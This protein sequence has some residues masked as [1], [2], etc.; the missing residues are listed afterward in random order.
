MPNLV[1]MIILAKLPLTLVGTGETVMNFST[2][3][4]PVLSE[5]SFSFQNWNVCT[6]CAERINS[7][8]PDYTELAAYIPRKKNQK[9]HKNPNKK[10]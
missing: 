2:T 7:P 6:G 10:S 8:T 9:T 4:L 5:I 1:Q 3:V